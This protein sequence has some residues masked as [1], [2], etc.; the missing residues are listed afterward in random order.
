MLLLPDLPGQIALLLLRLSAIPKIGYLPGGSSETHGGSCR[1]VRSHDQNY[2]P[3][4]VRTP[5]R[6]WQRGTVDPFTAHSSRWLWPTLR[7]TS[8]SPRLLLR[9]D[10]SCPN[11]Q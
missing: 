11:N 1:T 2:L 9:A 4:E 5:K 10:I 6:P 3:A 7:G 8:L